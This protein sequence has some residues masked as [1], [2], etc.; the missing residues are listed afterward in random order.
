MT[1]DCASCHMPKRR[2]QDVIEVVMTDHQIQRRPAPEEDRLAPLEP[3]VPLFEDVELLEPGGVADPRLADLYRT[4]TVLRAVPSS[5]AAAHLERLAETGL[6]ALDSPTLLYDLARTRLHH[7]EPAAVEEALDEADARFGP[8]PFS[9]ELRALAA[10]RRGDSE[11]AIRLLRELI[12]DSPRRPTAH[13][14]LGRLLL[15]TDPAGARPPLEE[16][17]RLRP[18]LFPAWLLLAEA[19]WGSGDREGAV[20]AARRALALDPRSTRAYLDL[21]TYLT[22]LERHTEARRYL[23]HG[24]EHAADPKPILERLLSPQ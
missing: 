8:Q 4:V 10:E 13:H 14:H 12:E 19:R 21:A 20:A 22:G 16:A 24:V 23:V 2:T 3:H 17:A 5:E 1:G 11:R 9:R 7:G 6:P 18:N 15:P